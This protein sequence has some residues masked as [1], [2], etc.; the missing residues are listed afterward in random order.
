MRHLTWIITLPVALLALSFSVSNMQTVTILLWPLPWSVELPLY[1][2]VLVA[3][4]VSF[5]AGGL[6][7][8][9]GGHGQRKAARQQKRRADRLERDLVAAQVRAGEAEARLAAREA[10]PVAVTTRLPALVP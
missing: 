8:W 9:L 5:F 10:V 2:L 4:V 1:A 7:A 6:T 3:M